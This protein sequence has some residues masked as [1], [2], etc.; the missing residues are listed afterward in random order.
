MNRVNKPTNVA[1]SLGLSLAA[2]L[3][4]TLGWGW[5]RSPMALLAGFAVLFAII[6]GITPRDVVAIV[7]GS[8]LAFFV[9]PVSLIGALAAF[10]LTQVVFELRSGKKSAV[11]TWDKFRESRK[12]AERILEECEV[13]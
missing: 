1:V 10:G 12:T 4:A 8:A 7:L 11:G 9:L 5:F 6:R 3:I 13:Q 2:I